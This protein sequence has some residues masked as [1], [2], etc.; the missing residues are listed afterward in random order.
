MELCPEPILLEILKYCSNSTLRSCLRLNKTFRK[1]VLHD[2]KRFN[3]VK[4]NSKF[5]STPNYKGIAKF[6]KCSMCQRPFRIGK[7]LCSKCKN[8]MFFVNCVP[9][10]LKYNKTWHY[11][12]FSGKMLYDDYYT[13]SIYKN[14]Y[15][16]KRSYTNSMWDQ[17]LNTIVFEKVKDG[18]KLVEKSY[19]S[20]DHDFPGNVTKQDLDERTLSRLLRIC[21]KG[22]FVM[23]NVFE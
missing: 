2:V 16:F 20:D 12:R 8:G 10:N 1:C 13:V 5:K 4:P 22:P 15:S 6:T 23:K 3:C 18:W 9:P 17:C 19:E 11:E 21:W 14:K 7:A